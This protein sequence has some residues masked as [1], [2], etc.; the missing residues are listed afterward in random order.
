[1][2]NIYFKS[3]NKKD[4]PAIL[5]AVILGFLNHFLYDWMGLSGNR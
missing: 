4:L 3:L 5:V 1:M 2:Q